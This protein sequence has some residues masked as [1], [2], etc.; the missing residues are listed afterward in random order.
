[1]SDVYKIYENI[2][3]EK[4]PIKKAMENKN[5]ILESNL[6][7]IWSFLQM[8]KPFACLSLSR[9]NMNGKQKEKAYSILKNEVRKRGLGYIEMFGGF[10]ETDI[11][12]NTVDVLE[13]SLLVPNITKQ[14]ALEIGQIG[15]KIDDEQFDPQ[16][17]ILYCDGNEFLGFLNTDIRNGEI[18]DVQAKF[19]YDKTNP[20]N[21]LP[22]SKHAIEKYF[23]VLKKGSHRY[24]KNDTNKFGFIPENFRLY[25]MYDSKLVHYEEN[26]SEAKNKFSMRIL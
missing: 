21:L 16:E 11:S 12:N 17:S 25:E 4:Y 9:N 20:R 7:R 3:N 26:L 10:V 19:I 1:M 14:D 24:R 22:M 5:Y 18:G 13:N 2:V 15:L 8:G 6:S 23:S